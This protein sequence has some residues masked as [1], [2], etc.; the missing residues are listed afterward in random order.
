MK[1]L[2]ILT[3]AFL[4][5]A[6]FS[7]LAQSGST[8]NLNLSNF[9]G[10]SLAA[11]VTVH[12]SKGDYKVTS[13]DADLLDIKVDGK[14]LGIAKKKNTPRWGDKKVEV[15]VSMPSFSNL[16]IAGSGDIIFDE[17]FDNQGDVDVSIAG[18][19]D[20]M[21]QGSCKMLNISIAGSGD[22]KAADFQSAKCDISIAGNGD[23]QVGE[24]NALNISIA[25]S[26]DVQYKGDPQI[27]K[28]IIGSGDIS[29]M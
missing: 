13:S 25:G 9:K 17:R 5:A 21:L 23:V 24:S 14:E 10:I 8:Q 27:E 3:L 18:N 11:P 6:S 15:Y 12:V 29:R 7:V 19:G 20:I 22:V 26:G 4:F 1:K 16:S 28:S 2:P